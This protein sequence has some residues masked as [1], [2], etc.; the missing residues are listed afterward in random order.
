M[1][2]L[3]CWK[4][5]LH[6]PRCLPLLQLFMLS[7]SDIYQQ[8]IGCGRDD[9][10]KETCKNVVQ[11]TWL[12]WKLAVVYKWWLLHFVFHPM[13]SCYCFT[14]CHILYICISKPLWELWI[15][16]VFPWG[17]EDVRTFGGVGWIHWNV[18]LHGRDI[19]IFAVL[20][21]CS[22]LYS[23][24]NSMKW[25]LTFDTIFF[26]LLRCKSFILCAQC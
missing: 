18:C 24:G 8:H 11:I 16:C 2:H 12:K 5:Y 7:F 4:K 14:V 15:L 9:I 1:W 23:S 13:I 26:F 22:I 6:S 10:P 17:Q 20:A 25:V 3:C 19:I 21:L